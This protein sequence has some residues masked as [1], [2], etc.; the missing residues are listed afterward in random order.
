MDVWSV[1]RI[2]ANR[3]PAVTTAVLDRVARERLDGFWIHLDADILDESVMPAVDSPSSGGL[4]ANELTLLLSDLVRHPAA[5]GIDICV[6]DPDLDP[7]GSHAK[8][9]ANI[10]HEALRSVENQRVT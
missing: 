3:H 8:T 10:V 7:D 9:L 6:F 5:V 1:D 2:R 4:D